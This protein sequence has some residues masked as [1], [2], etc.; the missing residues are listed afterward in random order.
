[1]IGAKNLTLNTCVQVSRSVSIEPSLEPP[2]P[3]GE[4]AALLTSACSMPPSRRSRM[5]EIARVVSAGVA[6][7]TWIWSSGPASQGQS[8]GNG[9]REQVITRQPAEEKRIPVAWPM[10]RLAPVRSSVRRG[11]LDDEGINGSLVLCHARFR[12]RHPRLFGPVGNQDVVGRDKPCRDHL[13][14]GIKPYLGPR[15]VRRVAAEFDAVVQ[16]E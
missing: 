10:P 3:F 11:A 4:I 7:S 12:A 9:C 5:S 15:A 6:R 1:M 14:L 16:A 8:S 2:A 13:S